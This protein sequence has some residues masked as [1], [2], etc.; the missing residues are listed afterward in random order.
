MIEDIINGI[1]NT[2][3]SVFG[4]NYKIYA[5]NSIEQG[6]KNPCFFISV[7]NPSQETKLKDRYFRTYPFIIQFFP[8]NENDNIELLNVAE[9]LTE[10]LE[11]ITLL[12]GDV[13][14]G[15]NFNY[16][17]VDGVLHF[18]INFNLF[19]RKVREAENK[20]EALKGVNF[21]R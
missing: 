15:S 2:I 13:L 7:L 17:V 6:L 3:Y 11:F 20:M 8:K 5:D 10:T 4:D 16:E 18:K 14:Q 21:G 1:S 12:N 9:I 19:L